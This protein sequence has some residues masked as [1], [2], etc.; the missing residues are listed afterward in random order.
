MGVTKQRGGPKKVADGWPGFAGR[1]RYAV[2]VRQADSPGLTQNDI[3]ARAGIDSGQFA[4]ILS[5]KR[6]LG[7][8]ANTVLLLADA[9]D[10]R[11]IWLMTGL[12]P[13]GL[14]ATQRESEAPPP[15]SIS[16]SPEPHKRVS[17]AR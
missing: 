10:V 7:A 1:L 6:A 15:S 9:L 8:T 3:A 16:G 11:P 2:G 5:G 17:A 12:E 4:K 14:K 13:S